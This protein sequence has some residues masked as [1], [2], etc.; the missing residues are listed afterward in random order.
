MKLKKIEDNG[1]KKVAHSG[2]RTEG[3]EEDRMGKPRSTVD[4]SARGGGGG[5]GGGGKEEEE[6]HTAMS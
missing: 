5:G 6:L 4:C 3:M 1:N 2:Y